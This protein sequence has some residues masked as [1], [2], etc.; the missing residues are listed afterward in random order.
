MT[1]PF[2]QV[3]MWLVRMESA[4]EH[5]KSNNGTKDIRSYGETSGHTTGSRRV[6]VRKRYTIDRSKKQKNIYSYIGNLRN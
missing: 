1:A 3:E 4:I 6:R 2:L 5:G